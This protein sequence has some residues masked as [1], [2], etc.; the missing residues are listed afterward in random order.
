MTKH[1]FEVRLTG[2]FLDTEG[3]TTGNL[4]LERLTGAGIGHAFQR[5]QQP[6]ASDPHYQERLYSLQTTPEHVAAA[7]GI[8]V[9]RPWVKA[10]AFK[11]G[12]SRLIAIG[13][14][15]IGYDKIDLKA[16]TEN[17]VIVFNSPH[18][19]NHSTASAAALFILALSKRLW[20]QERILREH[21]WDRQKEAVGDDLAGKTL[22]I[23]GLGHTARELVRLMAPYR[24]KVIAYSPHA[25]PKQAAELGVTL[26]PSMDEV[27]ERADYL[28]LHGRLTK[29][30][31]NLIGER[32][33]SLMKPTAFFV[34]IARGEMVDQGALT[35]A[36]REKRIAGAGLDVFQ[37]EPLAKNDPLLELD[38]VILTPHWLCTTHEAIEETIGSIHRGMINLS[39]GKL[40]ENILNPEVIERPGFQ[41]KLKRYA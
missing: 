41:E 15:G 5:D 28:S 31:H 35:R 30:T 12:A 14:A 29:D 24:M 26:L 17:D 16:C 9:L 11:N 33:L 8:I 34:N 21:R 13:R 10:D 6:Q 39:Q 1:K 2:D 25:D 19:L 3:K 18:G 23:I 36:L 27:I 7:E 22:S 4:Y 37:E 40:P 38:N 32:E 20:L